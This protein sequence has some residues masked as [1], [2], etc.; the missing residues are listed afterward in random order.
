VVEL[1]T[2]SNTH[3]RLLQPIGPP[4][5]LTKSNKWVS[6]VVPIVVIVAVLAVLGI[7]F[8]VYRTTS[9]KSLAELRIPLLVPTKFMIIPRQ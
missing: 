6:I 1:D 9:R 2:R 4:S 3:R 5:N 7:G 8:F